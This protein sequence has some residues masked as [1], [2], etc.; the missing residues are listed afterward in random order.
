MAVAASSRATRLRARKRFF[1]KNVSRRITELGVKRAPQTPERRA[2]GSGQ[3][4]GM[5]LTLRTA[6]VS[7]ALAR[8]LSV[9]T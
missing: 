8:L 9:E 1:P 5:F 3:R 4:D 2:R 6:I 7:R